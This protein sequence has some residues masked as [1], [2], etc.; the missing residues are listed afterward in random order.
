MSG[1]GDSMIN[2]SEDVLSAG[3]S[4]TALSY[5]VLDVPP[6]GNFRKSTQLPILEPHEACCVSPDVA[7][8][9]NFVRSI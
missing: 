5:L 1:V 2:I 9:F 6:R 7:T 4:P 8:Y 3:S